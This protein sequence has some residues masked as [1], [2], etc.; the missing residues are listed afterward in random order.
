MG[1]SAR[2]NQPARL[3]GQRLAVFPCL[4]FFIALAGNA[5][6]GGETC[7]PCQQKKNHVIRVPGISVTGPNVS[8]STPGVFVNKGGVAV[9]NTFSTGGGFFIGGGGG[10]FGRSFISSGGGGFIGGGNAV[11]S[12][13][14]NLN[15]E[16]EAEAEAVTE[17]VA[18]PYTETISK[19]RWVEGVFVLRAVCIDDKGVPHPASRP[20]P[21]DQVPPMYEGELFRCM[22][23]TSMQITLG[24]YADG[25]SRFD[26]ASTMICAK[27]EA[28]RHRVGGQLTCAP[29]EPR[30][31][32]NE[33]SLLRKFGPG[34]KVVRLRHQQNYT[35]QVTR[36]RYET[37][38][39]SASASASAKASSRLI[40]SGGVGN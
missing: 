29:Q 3:F 17:Q 1:V 32:C 36:T 31:N 25:Q 23:G 13:I 20:D 33:R 26:N 18:V 35:E 30:R 9:R 34:V 28:L 15:V 6:A 11:T 39:A 7:I 5:L 27:G 22:A 24:R 38:S 10:S 12:I 37:R 4:F 40:L 19:T 8:V 2:H 21:N 14:S 16:A